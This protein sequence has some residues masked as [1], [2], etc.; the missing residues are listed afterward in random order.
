MISLIRIHFLGART[1]KTGI[2]VSLSVFLS[3]LVPD[4]L[5]LLAGV[6]AIICMQPSLSASVKI[7]FARIQTTIIAGLFGLVFY[8]ALG[9]NL[10]ALGLAVIVLIALFNRLKWDDSIVLAGVTVT[11][12][13]SGGS[14]NIFYYTLGRVSSTLVGIVVATVINMIVIPPRHKPAFHRKLDN[15]TAAFPDLYIKTVD[16]FAGRPEPAARVL[17]DLGEL[18]IALAGLRQELSHLKTGAGS[19]YGAYL[20]G[21]RREEAALF[22]QAVNFL[23][24]ALSGMRKMIRAAR[25]CRQYNLDLLPAGAAEGSEPGNRGF[26]FPDER[27]EEFEALLSAIY[28]LAQLLGRLHSHVFSLLGAKNDSSPEVSQDMEEAEHLKEELRLRL[29]AWQVTHI[30]EL[31]QASIMCVY[32]IIFDL[33]EITDALVELAEASNAPVR[34]AARPTSAKAGEDIC[35]GGGG[36]GINH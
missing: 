35:S 11:A 29:R 10:I 7:G 32:R 12:I 17:G 28:E 22:E 31:D 26:S 24:R 15:L 34:N 16:I 14:G 30:K 27:N 1:I 3:G 8:F 21:I 5:P 2:A 4:S 25:S 6:A 20:E 23:D 33:E 18:K 9:T 13:M 19:F 36:G